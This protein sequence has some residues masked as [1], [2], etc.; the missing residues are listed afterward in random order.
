MM[1]HRVIF[2]E[3]HDE[4]NAAISAL[5]KT[6]ADNVV[7]VIPQK[8]LFFQSIINA[9]ILRTKAEELGKWVFIVT[10][11]KKG[12]EKM[13]LSGLPVFETLE[14]LEATAVNKVLLREQPP[15]ELKIKHKTFKVD[16]LLQKEAEDEEEEKINWR[17]VFVRPSKTTLGILALITAGLFFFVSVLVLPG[18][19]VYIKPERKTISTVVNITLAP[20]EKINLITR[21]LKKQVIEGNK[22]EATFE[23]KMI[24]QTV[25]KVFKGAHTAGEIVIVNNHD[26]PRALKPQTRFQSEKGIIY[27]ISDW[28]TVP[29][30][31]NGKNGE[32][33]V[34]VVADELDVFGDIVGDRGNIIAPQKLIVPGLPPA[35]QKVLWAEVRQNLEGG[36]TAWEPRVAEADFAMAKKAIEEKIMQEAQSDLESYIAEQNKGD[37]PKLALVPE[38]KY[39]KKK[40]L[41]LKVDESVLDTTAESF[42]VYGK[43]SVSSWAFKEADLLAILQEKLE[44]TVDLDMFLEKISP[45]SLA[46]NVFAEEDNGNQLKLSVNVKG[47]ETYLIEPETESGI[48]FVNRL[49]AEI[50]GKNEEEA[51]NIL[52]N[53]PEISDVKIALW[54]FFARRIPKLPENIAVKLWE[55]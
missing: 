33:A 29:A 48:R 55:E 30:A 34:Q 43:I 53:F 39:L 44:G 31:A 19:T 4:I 49:K 51:E 12:R 36:I 38:N 15:A 54:P 14:E 46:I 10:R 50:R 20:A 40:I 32:L 45:E 5:K 22:I 7:F 3:A 18:A 42:E 8:S 37:K 41:E 6:E 47:V 9:K 21:Q 23:K 35:G 16:D 11:D 2:L 26:E 28:V 1:N 17:E 52:V 24:F 27:R 13:E 25:T